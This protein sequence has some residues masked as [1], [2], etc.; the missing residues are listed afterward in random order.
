VEFA[1][2]KWVAPIIKGR[3]YFSTLNPL[4]VPA[5]WRSA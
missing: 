4:A 1:M 5:L 3:R 2:L